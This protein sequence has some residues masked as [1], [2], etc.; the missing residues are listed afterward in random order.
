MKAADRRMGKRC[1]AAKSCFGRKLLVRVG[2]GKPRMEGQGNH[3][4]ELIQVG[5]TFDEA[6][7]VP[8]GML[9]AAGLIFKTHAQDLDLLQKGAFSE[10]LALQCCVQRGYPTP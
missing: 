7:K 4:Q 9:L 1:G 6:G 8:T 3:V 5:N 10:G 2:N